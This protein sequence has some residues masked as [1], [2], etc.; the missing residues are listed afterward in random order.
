LT[1]IPESLFAGNVNATTF[2]RCFYRCSNLIKVPEGLFE[3]NVNATNFLGC[4]DECSSLKEIPEGLFQ[5][6]LMQQT[7]VGALVNVLV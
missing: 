5:I 4:F 6:M 3:N 2:V 7:L 1:E